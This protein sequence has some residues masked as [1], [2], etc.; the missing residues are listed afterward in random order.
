MMN[1]SQEPRVSGP[2][3]PLILAVLLAVM[4]LV[5]VAVIHQSRGSLPWFDEWGF[6]SDRRGWSVDTFLDPWNGHLSVAPLLLYKV[7]LAVAGLQH[8]WAFAAALLALH[9]VV[10]FGVFIFARRRVGE[11]GALIAASLALVCFASADN[12]LWAAEFGF[13]LAVAFGIWMM[14]WLD[15]DNKVGDL[16]AAICLAGALA[17]SALGPPFVV[18]AA[19]IIGVDD[20]RWRRAWVVAGPL[21]LF[22]LW[23]SAY[24]VSEINLSNLPL[25]PRYAAELGSSALGGLSGLGIS[26]GR[27]LFLVLGA[28]VVFHLASP[29]RT[30]V[31]LVALVATLL[32]L[33]CLTALNRIGI[34]TPTASRY[35]Y[36]SA[37]LVVLLVAE[38]CRGRRLSN[39]AAAIALLLVLA[40]GV[41][42][43]SV[44]GQYGAAQ[45]ALA[46]NLSAR[47]GA[48]AL[49]Q[50]DVEPSFRPAPRIDP[51]L[52]AGEAAVA[53][54]DFGTI[55]LSAK[56]LQSASPA[57]RTAADAVL[58]QSG[59]VRAVRSAK[60]V[61]GTPR[62]LS[63]H[64]ARALPASGCLE[65]RPT[66]AA[67]VDLALPSA[68]GLVAESSKPVPVYLRHFASRVP[69]RPS[70]ILPGGLPS[71]ITAAGA[72]V[73]S[74]WV[75]QLRPS[76]RLKLCRR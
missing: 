56:E 64:G 38:M 42:N 6:I 20:R 67:V 10:G 47:L 62:L 45:R 65:I 11:L 54:R 15:R 18:A 57:Q 70:L 23:Y 74:G 5:S 19:I 31:W 59:Q 55:R 2:A 22:V 51:T 46:A 4:V 14:V 32:A 68:G 73:R 58:I 35:I 49:V 40:A 17:S 33:W 36:P 44:L 71:R 21:L 24:G 60:P 16:L 26:Y 7:L 41:S 43:Y 3:R 12:L 75:V 28:A 37:M 34:V 8:H 48:L 63:L 13:M 50:D 29:R 25:V 76:E 53:Q 39:P 52:D 66:R 72:A 61:G 30:G 9:L 69:A 1:P 27:P